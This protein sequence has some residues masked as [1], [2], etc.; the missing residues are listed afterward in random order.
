MGKKVCVF[1][2]VLFDIIEGKEYIGGAPFNFSY[3][4]K[5]LGIEVIFISAVGKDS[6][7]KKVLDI[8][9]KIGIDT[10]FINVIDTP[11]GTVHVNVE[12]G[13]PTYNIV[14]PSAWDY[15]ELSSEMY[16]KLVKER[17]EY[18]YF[19]SLALRSE[20]SLK[21]FNMLTGFLKDS[22]KFCDINLRKPFYSRVILEKILN[23]ADILKLNQEELQE[24]SN[25]FKI[26]GDFRTKMKT[27]S[28]RFKIPIVCTTLGENGAECFWKGEF[29]SEKGKKV[30]VVD[31][32]GAGDAFAAGF[33]KGIIDGLTP[34]Q[35]LSLS[36]KL[37]A[38][39]VST[40][41]AIPSAF[42]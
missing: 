27:I 26:T 16:E 31:T 30:K 20:H 3:Y 22:V 8:A 23:F 39:A 19:G 36:N 40:R 9:R 5:S 29:Y 33:V 11:T 13:Q 12:N 25:I 6:R 38:E 32:V 2:E 15:I 7:G 42:C 24:I 37:G 28:T 10:S 35:V 18:F 21:T 41:G 4:L 17:P 34:Q 14:Y 1:G